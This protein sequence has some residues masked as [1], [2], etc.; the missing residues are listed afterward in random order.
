MAEDSRYHAREPRR[1]L[2]RRLL[3]AFAGASA[4][5]VARSLAFLLCEGLYFDSDQAVFGLMAKHLSEGKAF[6]LFMYGQR[7]LLAVSVW[8]AAPLVWLWGSQVFVIKLPLLLLNVVVC[9]VLLERL[10]AQARL[11]AKAAFA[12]LLPLL[13]PSVIGSSRLVEHAGIIEPFVWIL[14][15]WCL[16]RHA[17]AFGIVAGLGFL[18]REFTAYGVVALLAI[19]G[20]ERRWREPAWWR[21]WL[22]S[23]L[24]F[25]GVLATVYLLRPLSTNAFGTAPALK[26]KGVER[27][28]ARSDAVVNDFA[29]AL[30][31][32]TRTSLRRYAIGSDLECGHNVLMVLGVALGLLLVVRVAWLWMR[33]RP[34]LARLGLPLYLVLVG[35]LT[36]VVYIVFGRGTGQPAYVRYVPLL[37]LLPVGLVSAALV[38]ETRRSM[39]LL[40]VVALC[41]LAGANAWDHARVALACV[42]HSADSPHRVLADALVAR[43]VRTGVAPYWVAY[44][45]SYLSGERV[46]LAARGHPRLLEYE[47]LVRREG[48]SAVSITDSPC[49]AGQEA[50]A[51]WCLAA[52][53][54]WHSGENADRDLT[55]VQ[56]PSTGAGARAPSDTS[57]E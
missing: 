11:S 9:G 20:L 36:I 18:N 48:A 30:F 56:G 42:R 26:W 45:V 33:T 39:R 54:R 34:P 8:L 22:T 50:V 52:L 37:L 49:A 19:E 43:G 31:G 14:L 3:L 28:W 29:P 15:L 35:A 7:Y 5:V 1:A 4:I 6:P 53:G 24:A 32:W 25:G 40:V 41:V 21:A 44:Q 55:G 17:L 12:C 38:V 57:A 13:A 23:A 10:V 16:K 27:A 47:E 51:D 2:S 46:R